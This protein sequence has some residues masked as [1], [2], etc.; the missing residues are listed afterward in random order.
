MNNEFAIINND[1]YGAP[2]LKKVFQAYTFKGLVIAVTLHFAMLAAYMLFAYINES[3]AKDIPVNPN[4]PINFVEINTPPSIDDED[5]PPVKKDEIVQPLKDLAALEPQP[6]RKQDADDVILKTQDE[7]N[8][9]VTNVAREGDSLIASL[10]NNTGV[11]D[12]KIDDRLNNEIKDPPKDI[13]SSFEVEVAPECT[14]L[15]QVKS[16]MLYP[17]NAVQIGQEGKVTVKVLVGPEGDVLKIGSVSGP[18]VFHDEVKDK[19]KNLQF[20]PG[21]QN[22]KPVKVWVTVPFSFKLK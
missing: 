3:K 4:K 16:S 15:Q 22:N 10:N 20:T 14:N 6:V 8:N 9:I 12:V 11:D 13:Y 1:K 19:A 21:L 7:L 2:E 17:E 5:I 18:D